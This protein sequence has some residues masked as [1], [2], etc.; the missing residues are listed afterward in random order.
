MLVTGFADRVPEAWLTV[1]LLFQPGLQHILF[2]KDF[3]C[4]AGCNEPFF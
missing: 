1:L 2:F 3:L 4:L